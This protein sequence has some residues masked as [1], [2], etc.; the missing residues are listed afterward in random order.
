M[1]QPNTNPSPGDP[2][3][4]RPF[5]AAPT[6]IAPPTRGRDAAQIFLIFAALAAWLILYDALA[7]G[8][9]L[10]NLASGAGLI[11]NVLGNGLVVLTLIAVFLR[12]GGESRHAL[13]LSPLLSWREVALGLFAIIPCYAANLFITFAYLVTSGMDL[14]DVS[15]DKLATA[16]ML[17]PIPV[18]MI[19]PLA[20]FIGVYEEIMFRGFLLSRLRR[21][22]GVAPDARA[23][24][25]RL[26]AAVLVSA[27]LFGLIHF[28]QGP[29]G[30]AQTFAVGLVLAYV[31]VAR[32]AIW[33]CIVAH[34]GIDVFGIFL[35]RVAGPMLED[36]LNSAAS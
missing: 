34:V 2:P 20:V 24:C 36:F 12:R 26:V 5:V 6:P 16:E 22:F 3:L 29:L 7:L 13:G 8:P 10:E 33:A 1:T 18:A 30:M 4:A 25:A 28:Y 11:A 15:R 23:W 27:I 32:G 14:T 19:V 31:A 35:L 21:L 9:R 17:S